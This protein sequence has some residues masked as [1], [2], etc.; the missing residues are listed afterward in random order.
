MTP[1]RRAWAFL[2]LG[3][4]VAR[5]AHADP[6]GPP[7]ADAQEPWLAEVKTAAE[8]ALLR[9]LLDPKEEIRTAAVEE[10]ERDRIDAEEAAHARLRAIVHSQGDLR[11]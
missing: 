1:V 8:R 5:A 4:V 9:R 7:V 2:L 3:T 6:P 10:W 11:Q